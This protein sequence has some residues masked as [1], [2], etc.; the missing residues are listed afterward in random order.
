MS[1]YEDLQCPFCKET[2]FDAIGLKQHLINGWCESFV[3]VEWPKSQAVERS[4]GDEE[5]K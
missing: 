3:K 2:E 5:S 4:S 1:S